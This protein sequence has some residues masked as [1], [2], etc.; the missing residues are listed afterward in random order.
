MTLADEARTGLLARCAL[1]EGVDADGLTAL[2]RRASEVDFPAGHVIARQGDIG[3]GL[4][5]I[6]TGRA[7]VVRSGEVLATLGP[8]DFF[9][10]LSV[11]DHMP[12][13]ASVVAEAPTHCL[14]LASWDLE[15]TVAESPAVAMAILRGL[16][17]R[18]R[19]LTEANRH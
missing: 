14:A 19:G 18:L 11:L 15:A 7:R 2:G 10:E 12:R 13:T 17:Q 5:V 9:G 16:A 8:G 3:T 4:F 6:V 1:F